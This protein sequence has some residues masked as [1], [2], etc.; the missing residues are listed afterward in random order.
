MNFDDLCFHRVFSLERKLLKTFFNF[1]LFKGKR[2]Y[3]MIPWKLFCPNRADSG[4][5]YYSYS[6]ST[7][8]E[9]IVSGNGICF[10]TKYVVYFTIIITFISRIR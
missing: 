5:Y 2:S 9:I 7:T 1:P 3:K 10:S 4:N 6:Y 8:K